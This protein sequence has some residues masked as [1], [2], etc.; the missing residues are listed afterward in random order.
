MF[1]HAKMANQLSIRVVLWYQ[2]VQVAA[3]IPIFA[4]NAL[5]HLVSYSVLRIRIGT[6]ANAINSRIILI[7]GIFR[8]WESF[9]P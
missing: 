1:F 2:G 7:V 8:V 4:C 5:Q 3:M 9:G 6:V